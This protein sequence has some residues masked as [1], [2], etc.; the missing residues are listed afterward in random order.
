[1]NR[2]V[3]MTLERLLQEIGI[4]SFMIF[5]GVLLVHAQGSDG[6]WWI[7]RNPGG[8]LVRKPW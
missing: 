5:L 2:E 8:G 6:A 4:R 7:R 3:P 1:M